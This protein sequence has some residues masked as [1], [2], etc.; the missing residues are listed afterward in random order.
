[1]SH[2]G[3][4]RWLGDEKEKGEQD[5]VWN[6]VM[7]QTLAQRKGTAAESRGDGVAVSR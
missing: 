6:A 3:F 5:P 1:M 2:R 4:I 7:V